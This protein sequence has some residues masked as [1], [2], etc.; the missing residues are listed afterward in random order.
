MSAASVGLF[1]VPV[2]AIIG[3]SG[4]VS[5]RT[6]VRSC[7]APM[8]ARGWAYARVELLVAMRAY[9][10]AKPRAVAGSVVSSGTATT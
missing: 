8:P 10:W 1:D 6:C 5:A 2:M 7:R 9:A 3:D 4:E